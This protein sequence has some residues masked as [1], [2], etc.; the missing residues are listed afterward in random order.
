MIANK[1][2]EERL[3]AA[4]TAKLAQISDFGGRVAE[5][6]ERRLNRLNR[7]YTELKAGISQGIA[8][9]ERNKDK[10]EEKCF[11]MP[12]REKIKENCKK[13]LK[14]H[15]EAVR[16]RDLRQI[17]QKSYVLPYLPENVG[18]RADL[19]RECRIYLERS[20]I[21]ANRLKSA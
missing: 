12:K 3:N 17:G 21:S 11:V 19:L 9:E 2:R 13:R 1:R 4:Q 5:R 10:S 15:I 7:L 14:R 8:K 18:K 6:D 16:Q 20:K